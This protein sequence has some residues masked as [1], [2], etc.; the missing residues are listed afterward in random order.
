MFELHGLAG[1]GTLIEDAHGQDHRA[2]AVT[3]DLERLMMEGATK[4]QTLGTSGFA[5]A[6]LRI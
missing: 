2:A 5:G 4:V 3:Y 6:L 1:S